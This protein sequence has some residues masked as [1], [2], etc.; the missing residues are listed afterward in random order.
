MGEKSQQLLQQYKE[1]AGKL[2][3]TGLIVQGSLSAV[4][5]RCG[6]DNCACSRDEARKHGDYL[7][8]T[9]KHQGKTVSKKLTGRQAALWR[10]FIGNNKRIKMF[11]GRMRTL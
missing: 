10:E 9:Y 8:L 1:L 6:K 7:L 2:A 3:R 11:L 5:Y 4:R